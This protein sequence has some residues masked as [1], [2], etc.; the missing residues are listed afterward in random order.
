MKPRYITECQPI[1]S[2][3]AD[4]ETKGLTGIKLQKADCVN[5]I[6]QKSVKCAKPKER[7]ASWTF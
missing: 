6:F 1:S 7:S 4:A 2:S 5:S 3:L